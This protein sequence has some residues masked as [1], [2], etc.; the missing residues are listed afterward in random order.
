MI[1]IKAS[2]TKPEESRFE[3]FVTGRNSPELFHFVEEPFDFVPLFILLFVIDNNLKTVCFR[4]DDRRDAL[5]DQLGADGVAIVSLVQS[6][7]VQSHHT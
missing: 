6:P 2:V 7:P 3:F 4:W 5:G 1:T